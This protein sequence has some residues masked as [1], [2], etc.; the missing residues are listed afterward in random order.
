MPE[1][2]FRDRLRAREQEIELLRTKL[3]DALRRR[4]N[5]LIRTVRK[6]LELAIRVR[7]MYRRVLGREGKAAPGGC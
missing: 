1:D 5:D 6:Q 2:Y 3:D 4:N 7:D